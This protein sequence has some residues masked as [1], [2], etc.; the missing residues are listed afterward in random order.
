MTHPGDQEGLSAQQG[1]GA[2]YWLV[3]VS[4]SQHLVLLPQTGSRYMRGNRQRNVC[5]PKRPGLMSVGKCDL[6][7]PRRG[8]Y[9]AN[10]GSSR[11]PLDFSI[12]WPSLFSVCV[13]GR[14]HT[15]ILMCIHAKAREGHQVSPSMALYPVAR[16]KELS[17]NQKLAASAQLS[18]P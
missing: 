5:L 12:I 15:Y 11:K 4:V 3:I 10:T 7:D 13:G 2:Q 6:Q 18:G 8:Q 16:R 17:L 9:G 14:T 1:P